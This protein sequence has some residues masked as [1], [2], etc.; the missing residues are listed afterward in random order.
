[1]W[2]SLL[3]NW[4]EYALCYVL[5]QLHLHLLFIYDDHICFPDS[6]LN[7]IEQEHSG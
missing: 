4:Y 6:F 2:Y 5:L 3:I 7:T 1:M